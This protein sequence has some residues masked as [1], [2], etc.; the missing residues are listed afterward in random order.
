MDHG[1]SLQSLLERLLERRE[2]VCEKQA[3]AYVEQM[4]MQKQFNAADGYGYGTRLR[5]NTHNLAKGMAMVIFNRNNLLASRHYPVC[6]P[7][8]YADP[9]EPAWQ[10]AGWRKHMNHALEY[11]EIR[12]RFTHSELEW[13]RT[14]IYPQA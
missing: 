1:A 7:E 9:F 11:G 12:V 5:R 3:V 10:V 6:R 2:V 13:M 14:G 8:I 4:E